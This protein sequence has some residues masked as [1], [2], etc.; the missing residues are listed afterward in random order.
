MESGR[1]SRAAFAH[2]CSLAIYDYR[3]AYRLFLSKLEL[4]WYEESGL[5]Y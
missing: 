2:T 3:T 5:T 1:I 4:A